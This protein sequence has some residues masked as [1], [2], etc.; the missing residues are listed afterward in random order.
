MRYTRVSHGPLL[1]ERDEADVMRLNFGVSGRPWLL[2]RRAAPTTR[3]PRREKSQEEVRV[4]TDGRRV[5]LSPLVR[6][7]TYTQT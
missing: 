6:P 2:G 5:V 7:M 4:F 3:R 1:V